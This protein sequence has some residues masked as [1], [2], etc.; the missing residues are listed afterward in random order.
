ML[1]LNSEFLC[2]F[3]SFVGLMFRPQSKL[4]LIDDVAQDGGDGNPS[5][6]TRSQVQDFEA[7]ISGSM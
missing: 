7:M 4:I 5:R 3:Y 2:P 6:E 1:K